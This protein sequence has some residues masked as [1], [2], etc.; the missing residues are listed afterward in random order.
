MRMHA[1]LWNHATLRIASKD[2]RTCLAFYTA[3]LAYAEAEAKAAIACQLARA[4]V[5]V[6]KLERSA[7]PK[8]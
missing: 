4:H 7:Q 1:L 6:Q 5:A 2:Y 3:A 8:V